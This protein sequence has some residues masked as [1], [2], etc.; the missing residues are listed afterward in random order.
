MSYILGIDTGGTY[1]DSIIWDNKNQSLLAKS[2]SLTTYGELST[3]I[4]NSINALDFKEYNKIAGVSLST[5]LATN[6]IVEKRG[7]EVGLIIIGFEPVKE[8]PTKYCRIVEGGHNVNGTPRTAINTEE[9]CQVIKEFKGKVDAIAVSGYFSIRNPEHELEVQKLIHEILDIPVVCAHQLT[10]SLG[11]HERTVTAVL[12][13]KLIPIIKELISSVKTVLTSLSINA[14]LMIVKGDGTLMSE[15][16]AENKPIDTILSGP[17]ASIIG[18]TM[19]TNIP[20]TIDFSKNQVSKSN[21]R[22]S[23]KQIE[24]NT[25]GYTSSALI[26]DMGGTTTDIAILNKGIPEINPE[27]A[28]V[29]GWS[30]R[31]RSAEI[32]T[33]GIGGDSCIDTKQDTEFIDNSK[34]TSISGKFSNLISLTIGPQ[35]IYPLSLTAHQYP[36]LKQELSI[37]LNTKKSQ[38][39]PECY[40]LN[41]KAKIKNLTETE[42]E[43]VE[44]LKSEPHSYTFISEKLQRKSLSNILNKLININ[45]IA[46]SSITPTDILHAKGVYTDYSTEAAVTGITVLAKKMGISYDEFINTAMDSIVNK[47][48]LTILQSLMNHEGHIVQIKDTPEVVYFLNK[49]LS[50]NSNETYKLNCQLKMPIIAIGAPVNAYL[51]KVAEKLN[52]ELIIPKHAEVANAIGAAAG[53]IMEKINLL[54]KTDSKGKIILHTPKERKTF[55]NLDDAKEYALKNGRK[56]I[57]ENVVNAGAANH[58]IT[59]NHEDIYIKSSESWRNQVYLETRIE[60]TAT[61]Q[62]DW[63]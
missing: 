56:I 35:K 55:N 16:M 33:F 21:S 5:T 40:I 18:S 41:K 31:V 27:G 7:C 4:Q 17:A 30:T 26:L 57:G 58:R 28:Q 1:T 29:G 43:I 24:T 11:F 49:M 34:Q 52:A 42:K 9:I 20:E 8:L 22:Q 46:K 2:K 44:I 15:N 63:N 47:L 36:H 3:G 38:L 53:N 51:P 13:G 48:C 45:I 39:I 25:L 19:L 61:G 37:L 50:N 10:T 32:N 54:I 14:P 59:V 23:V 62:P 6:A 60:I 12:N